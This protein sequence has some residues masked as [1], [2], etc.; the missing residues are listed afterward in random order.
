MPD[1]TG[2]LTT[3]DFSGFDP[4]TLGAGTTGTVDM[5][6]LKQMAQQDPASMLQNGIV[7]VQNFA[8][9]P[10]M[11]DGF[12]EVTS[13]FQPSSENDIPP[14]VPQD[15]V[16]KTDCK[17]LCKNAFMKGKGNPDG[18]GQGG[19]IDNNDDGT[20]KPQLANDNGAPVPPSTRL[21]ATGNWNPSEGASG[22][23]SDVDSDPGAVSST[24]SSTP[25]SATNLL[26]KAFSCLVLI[27][28]I[29]I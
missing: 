4:A 29:M 13:G 17:W 15:C 8:N 18:I 9:E 3:G 20:E 21:L 16:S 11:A 1:M 10:K 23:N 14:K 26:F 22:T 28:F 6:S 12:P 27:A 24:S 7:P 25:K 5:T 19:E 2:S